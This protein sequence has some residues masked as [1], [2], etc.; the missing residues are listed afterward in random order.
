MKKNMPNIVVTNV[1]TEEDIKQ[2]YSI[3]NETKS[4]TFVESLSYTSY[5]I[6]LPQT[7]IDKFTK[8]ASDIAGV[9]VEIREYNLSR[10]EKIDRGGKVFHPLLFPHTDEAFKEARITLDYQIKSNIDWS[11]TV[12]DWEKENEF[13]LKD[14]ELLSFAGTHQIHWRNKKAFEF[15]DFVEAIFMHF[16][17]VPAQPLSIEHI[18]E[19]RD[20][21]L[22][23]YNKWKLQDGPTQNI[24]NDE[25]DLYK[26]KKMEVNN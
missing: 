5:H 23:N 16:S 19:V 24:G 14:N 2:I 26:Y 6:Q 25:T 15:G 9:P 10:Y 11:I 18:N 3:L 22:Y 12:D 13:T 17:P 1:L 8:I 7:I 4:Q 21:G 20:R